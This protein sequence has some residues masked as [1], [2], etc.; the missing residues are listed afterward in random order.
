MNDD[1]TRTYAPTYAPLGKPIAASGV[2][3][4]LYL[5]ATPIGNLGDISLRALETLAAADCIACEDTR[6]TRKLTE[7]YGIGTHLMSYHEHNADE[8]LPKI[9]ARLDQGQSVAL[10]SDAGTPLISDPGY[11]L[12]RA[13]VEAGHAVTALPGASAVLAALSLAGLP[14]DRFFFEGFLPP[15]QGARQ[16]RIAELLAIPATLVLFESG[17]RLGASL[18][19]LAAGL[20]PRAAAVCRE[21][22]K[23]HEE[24][25]RDDLATLAAHYEEDAETRGEIVI[26]IAPPAEVETADTDVD[27]MLRKALA[28]VSVKDA[29]G[30]VALA[31]GRARRDVYQRALELTKDGTNAE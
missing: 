5:V 7:R 19:D 12:V 14:T 27:D 3:P 1:S 26:V 29:V 9:I 31:T 10:V 25:R 20:G 18:A 2:E 16:K 24:I 21:L 11:R 28:R 13:T 6:V 17:P 15:K 23:M 8:A 22:T 4:G 30:E